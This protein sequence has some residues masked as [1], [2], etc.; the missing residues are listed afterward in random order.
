MRLLESRKKKTG[1]LNKWLNGRRRSWQEEEEEEEEVM[2]M[3]FY[4]EPL[5]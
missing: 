3:S 4:D 2:S 5:I 1:A